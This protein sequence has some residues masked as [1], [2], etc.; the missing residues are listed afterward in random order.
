MV[1]QHRPFGFADVHFMATVAAE[2]VRAIELRQLHATP[3]QLEQTHIL[4]NHLTHRT[5]IRLAIFSHQPDRLVFPFADGYPHRA[6]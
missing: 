3:S 6:I 4:V 1:T 2:F 5:H